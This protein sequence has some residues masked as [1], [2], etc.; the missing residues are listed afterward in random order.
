MDSA[1]IVFGAMQ[2][3]ALL[4]ALC[5]HEFAHAAI[6]S[7]LGDD[8]AAR[9]GRLTLS[10]LAHADPI[11]TVLLPIL[12]LLAGGV[13][14]GW[15]RPTPVDAGNFRRGWFRSG[16][17]LVAAGGPL[18]NL[19]QA[20]CWAVLYAG[21]TRVA[22]FPAEEGTPVGLLALFVEASIQINLVLCLFNLLPVP[23]LDGGHVAS[24]LLPRAAGDA[25]DSLVGRAGIFLLVVLCV[26]LFHGRSIV[27][28]LL[29]PARWATRALLT[30][31]L[32]GWPFPMLVRVGG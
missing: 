6:A 19:A 4:L 28:F 27:S 9:E 5:V 16:Q 24:W 14:F 30:E 2:Y 20:A 29:A 7:A 31:P 3:V 17:I 32:S 8:T 21:L 11:G 22:P 10:P 13:M 12:G 1:Q 23:P 26:P 18:S 25:Y 15:A